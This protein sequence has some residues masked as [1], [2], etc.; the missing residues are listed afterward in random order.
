MSYYVDIYENVLEI[1]KENII[2]GHIMK[3]MRKSDAMILITNSF[4]K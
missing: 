3:W 4:E 2:K 1:M